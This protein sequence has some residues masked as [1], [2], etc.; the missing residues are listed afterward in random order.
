MIMD[1]LI[2]A[3]QLLVP[4]ICGLMC[5]RYRE[6]WITSCV[7]SVIA[8]ILRIGTIEAVLIWPLISTI[9]SG[10]GYG[11]RRAFLLVRRKLE[12]H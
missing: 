7:W 10:F 12:S 6:A 5:T 11:I 1:R 3:S 9:L 2:A 8:A 4:I